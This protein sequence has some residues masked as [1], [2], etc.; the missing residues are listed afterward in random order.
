MRLWFCLSVLLLST[1]FSGLAFAAQPDIHSHSALRHGRQTIRQP[2]SGVSDRQS[3]DSAQPNEIIISMNKNA[4]LDFKPG[5]AKVENGSATGLTRSKTIEGL[6]IN[7]NYSS[8]EAGNA[9]DTESEPGP[10]TLPN[11]LWLLGI[12]ILWILGIRRTW[13]GSNVA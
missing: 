13:D 11:A 5:T 4:D 2:N 12:G 1:T 10:A 7:K 6:Y 3:I 9:D 8:S